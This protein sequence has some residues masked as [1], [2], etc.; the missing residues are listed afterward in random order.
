MIVHIQDQ[1]GRDALAPGDMRHGGEVFLLLGRVAKF[2]AVALLRRRESVHAK[3]G[4]GGLDHG[5]Y[6][7]GVAI[8]G[9]AAQEHVE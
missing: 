1:E 3:A 4:L 6:I 7:V 9:H 5:R 2:D 8:H